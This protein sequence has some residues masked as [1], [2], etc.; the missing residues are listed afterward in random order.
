MAAL[1]DVYLRSVPVGSIVFPSTIAMADGDSKYY[2]EDLMKF[3]PNDDVFPALVV[4]AQASTFVSLLTPTGIHKL[5]RHAF[6]ARLD[7]K[8]PRQ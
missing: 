8:R 7:R 4:S 6:V 5:S 3:V 2:L 1:R